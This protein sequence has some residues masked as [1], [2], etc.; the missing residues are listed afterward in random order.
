MI[1]PTPPEPEQPDPVKELCRRFRQAAHDME[2]LVR[3]WPM[4]YRFGNTYLGFN[5]EIQDWRMAADTMEQQATELGIA[6]ANARYWSG[7]AAER[8]II[9]A[10]L[11]EEQEKLRRQFDQLV[12]SAVV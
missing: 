3:E 9:I 10:G 6:K 2:A 8:N 4:K 1:D 12:S 5:Q 11:G 7:I